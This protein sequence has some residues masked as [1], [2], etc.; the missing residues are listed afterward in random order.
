MLK[1]DTMIDEAERAIHDKTGD[2]I[3]S[4]AIYGGSAYRYG[5]PD[6]L[7]VD[8]CLKRMKDVEDA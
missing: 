8:R 3:R 1:G 4:E 2:D 5:L 7:A 6:C